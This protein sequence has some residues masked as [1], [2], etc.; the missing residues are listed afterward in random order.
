[1][2]IVKRKN[3]DPFV[4]KDGSIIREYQH[5]KETSLAEAVVKDETKPRYHKS[6]KEIYYILEGKGFMKIEGETKQVEEDHAIIIPPGKTHS[7]KN[8]GESNLRILC[9]CHPSYAD[10]DTLI[11][12]HI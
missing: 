10:D 2:Q 9:Y 5:S 8:I 7:I 12:E 4:T 3:L 1:M 6:S 11:K